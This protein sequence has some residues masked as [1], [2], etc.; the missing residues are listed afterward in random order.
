MAVLVTHLNAFACRNQLKNWWSAQLTAANHRHSVWLRACNKWKS[1]KKAKS[2]YENE[3]QQSTNASTRGQERRRRP[4]HSVALWRQKLNNS[5]NNGIR[6]YKLNSGTTEIYEWKSC[7]AFEFVCCVGANVAPATG[8][9][10]M[11]KLACSELSSV[12]ETLALNSKLVK[13]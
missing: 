6:L 13:L 2:K 11:K 9:C 12:D 8:M 3:R 5:G 7:P 1:K 10:L 4:Q